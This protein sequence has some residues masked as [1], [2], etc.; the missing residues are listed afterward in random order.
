MSGQDKDRGRTPVSG[1]PTVSKVGA[2]WTKRPRFRWVRRLFAVVF[3]LVLLTGVA[4]G[5]FAWQTY[6]RYAADLPTPDEV[7]RSLGETRGNPR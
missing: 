6:E 3:T 7:I 5:L 2:A 4:G 1:A